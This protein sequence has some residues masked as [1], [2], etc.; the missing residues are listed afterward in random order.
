MKIVYGE[1]CVDISTIRRWAPRV[2]DGN[3]RISF[4]NVK[5]MANSEFKPTDIISSADR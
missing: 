2:R 1:E 4:G 5:C 3:E